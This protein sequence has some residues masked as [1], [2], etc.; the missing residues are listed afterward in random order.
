M[1][2]SQQDIDQDDAPGQK[3]MF[4]GGSPST[5]SG[6][7]RGPTHLKGTRSLERLRDRIELA[8]KE[9]HRLREE[10]NALRRELEAVHKGSRDEGDGTNVVF[11]ESPD[12]L[13]K[14]LEDYI[15]LVDELIEA[16]NTGTETED[17]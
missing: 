2:P 16:E 1:A 15:H 8:V 13:R 10:N 9:L 5:K 7:K 14:K 17:A 4:E 12:E 11:T 6:R 3:S